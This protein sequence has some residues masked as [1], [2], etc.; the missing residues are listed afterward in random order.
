MGT[1]SVYADFTEWI[2]MVIQDLSAECAYN[3]HTFISRVFPWYTWDAIHR[4]AGTCILQQTYHVSRWTRTAQQNFILA[5][6]ELN[7]YQQTHA[8]GI[9][10]ITTHNHMAQNT[11]YSHNEHQQVDFLPK[12]HISSYKCSKK[13]CSPIPLQY[14]PARHWLH[15]VVPAGSALELRMKLRNWFFGLCKSQLPAQVGLNRDRCSST[16]NGR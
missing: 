11:Y 14:V 10:F 9:R 15:A 5:Q 2:Q 12:S 13:T 1:F 6:Q 16:S 8:N 7:L 3:F 4:W